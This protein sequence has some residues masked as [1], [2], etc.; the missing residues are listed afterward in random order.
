MSQE[1]KTYEDIEQLIKD[2]LKKYENLQTYTD[3]GEYR[4]EGAVGVLED[5]LEM[6]NS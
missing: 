5:L 1:N 4:R 2:L 6:I 3:C